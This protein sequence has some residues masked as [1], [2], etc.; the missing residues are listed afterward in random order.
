MTAAFSEGE[1]WGALCSCGEN[2]APR[3]DDFNFYF[4]KRFWPEIKED[5]IQL[6]ARFHETNR[7][8]ESIK[9]SHMILI[10]KIPSSCAI[11]NFW[12]IA[13]IHGI[14]KLV[15][16]VLTNRIQSCLTELISDS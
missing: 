5:F 7:L 1:I 6:F 14:Y 10:L 12:Q 9:T 2:K 15:A 16:K 13:L 11:T 8:S 3:P 4:Y